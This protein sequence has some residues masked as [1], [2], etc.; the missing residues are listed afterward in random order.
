MKQLVCSLF[1]V[2]ICLS[3]HSQ[4]SRPLQNLHDY[5]QTNQPRSLDTTLAVLNYRPGGNLNYLFPL[6]QLFREEKKFKA[7]L[8]DS[9]YEQ[10]SVAASL[11]EDY[12]SALQYQKLSYK[13][14]VSDVQKRQIAKVLAGFKAIQHVDARRYISFISRSARVIMIN[15]APNKPLHRAF[16]MS[17]LE[18]L[19]KKG[20]RYLAM[21][22]LNNFSN[23]ELD[24]LTP[25]TGQYSTEPVAGEL[26]RTALDIGY[27][28]V[29][30]ED[31]LMDQHSA[32]QR[33]S[34]QAVN[35]YRVIR[36]DSTAKI[37]VH[38]GYAHI[39]EKNLS[40]D[41]IPMAMD[42]KKISGIDPITIDQTDMT[43]ESSFAYGKY[44]YES[45]IQKFPVYSPSV[46]LIDEQP[47]NV[48]SSDLYDISVIHPTTMYRDSRPT[49]LALTGRRQPLYIKPPQKD[50]YLV[51][52]YYQFESL[53]TKP[54]QVIPADQTYMP[55][56]KGN[57][58]LYL[59]RGKYIILFRD[60]NYKIL[61]TQH[62]EVS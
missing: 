3:S 12:E 36:E 27:K 4:G 13:G 50:V 52:A 43:E 42:F 28:L 14:E 31:T 62:I 29:S 48:T 10:L 19:Y 7:S 23:H 56:N 16:T 30:Y 45:Y 60:I 6:Y 18:D 21:E 54:G 1:V 11:T 40:A 35:I 9:Y 53:G 38:A 5:L 46:A 17:L 26:I 2:L 55:T 34:I 49:W 57:Y 61:K 20:Y 51:Q 37:L 8:G 33:D 25:L 41:Y 39:A 32:S 59:K 15:E 47:V 44:F 22:M 58:L 24:K